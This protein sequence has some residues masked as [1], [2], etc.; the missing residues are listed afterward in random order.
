MDPNAQD[1][2]G[3]TAVHVAAESRDT[4]WILQEL[5]KAGGNPNAK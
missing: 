3:T 4:E 1:S 5:L 2:D